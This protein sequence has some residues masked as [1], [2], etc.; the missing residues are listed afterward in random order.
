M[1]EKE[2][3][4][5]AKEQGWEIGRTKKGHLRYVPPDPR[6]PIVIGSGTPGDKRALRNFL[7]QLKRAGFIWPWPLEKGGKKGK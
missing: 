3:A 2:I 5:A 7:A 1:N 6:Q 4:Q